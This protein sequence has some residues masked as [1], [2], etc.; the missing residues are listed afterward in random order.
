MPDAT[1]CS[2][3][4]WRWN[5]N[6]T[7]SSASIRRR[8]QG[9]RNTR[10]MSARR[11]RPGRRDDHPDRLGV[12]LPFRELGRELTFAEGGETIVLRLAVVFGVAP[13]GL[14]PAALLETMQRRVERALL[15]LQPVFRDVL[16]P[17]Q[18]AQAVHRTPAQRLEDDEVEGAA[19][20]VEIGHG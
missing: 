14:E 13:F 6:S 4:S 2:I 3:L 5:W 18:D 9:S 11:R 12:P 1:N 7:A 10:F 20:E 19:D 8:L 17:A 15:D 16:D